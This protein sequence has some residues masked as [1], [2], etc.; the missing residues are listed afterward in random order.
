[1]TTPAQAS[2]HPNFVVDHPI[3]GPTDEG[4]RAHDCWFAQN[5]V[6]AHPAC[7]DCGEGIIPMWAQQN[8]L[9]AFGGGLAENMSFGGRGAIGFAHP[10]GLAAAGDP[11]V[12]EKLSPEQQTWVVNTLVKLNERITSTTGTKCLT[13]APAID[14]AGQCF[15]MWFDSVNQGAP[16]RMLRTDGV[17]DK[18]TL[19]ALITTTQI[20]SADF[21]TPFPGEAPSGD[22]KLSTGAM[23][24]I[25]AAGAAVLGGIVYVAT[26]KKR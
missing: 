9:R 20:H 13:W 26:R 12:W 24:G 17:F 21:P 15:Q 7:V 18:D 1:M 6:P 11:S 5:R 10:P 14:K 23:V 22:K 16:I 2:G 25:A 8:R 3:Q 4:I 19:D